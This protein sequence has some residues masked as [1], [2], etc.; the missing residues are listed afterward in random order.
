MSSAKLLEAAANSISE[1]SE[2][3]GKPLPENSFCILPFSHLST[4][5]TGG[6]RL[7][8]RSANIEDIQNSSLHSVWR[9]EK[10]NAIRNQILAG[11]RVPECQNC[12]KDEDAG[13]I[14]LRKGQNIARSRM[15]RE[16]VRDY[17][18]GKDIP[19]PTIELKLSNRCNLKCMMCSP[20][21]SI[22]WMKNWNELKKY[23]EEGHRKWIDEV[24]ETNNMYAKPTL[25]FF[26]ANEKFMEE[27][28]LGAKDIRML[29]FAGGEP[30]IDPLHYRILKKVIEVGHPELV[31]LRYSTNLSVLEFE[32]LNILDLW[33][34]F[35]EIHLTISIDGF[36][37]LNAYIRSGTV[38]SQ[39][40]ENVRKV[41]ALPMVTIIKGT[42]T[43][44]AY[45][46]LFAAET[47]DYIL[48]T[49]GITWH[50]SRVT[51]PDFMDARIWPAENK[52]R[53][54]EKVKSLDLSTYK[55]DEVKRMQS[56]RHIDDYVK[57]MESDFKASADYV[58]RFWAFSKEFNAT[59]YGWFTDLFE[60]QGLESSSKP[61]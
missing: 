30:L 58:D 2:F 44:S 51:A 61:Y 19:L 37:E 36:R 17:L 24:I 28:A 9:S 8:C 48:G 10:V 34:K 49:L 47:I 38:P 53:A 60:S 20:T 22:R 27:F 14:S 4:T 45:N 42:T 23:Y 43:L 40:E 16:N 7:C 25:D 29:D 39:L 15:F 6:I 35:K 11:V 5:T 41:K 52:L 33:S 55:I 26:L 1:L 57:W 12:W 32:K 59:D 46:G 54:I 21:A 50:T 56:Q 3:T 31:T 13:V 18:E